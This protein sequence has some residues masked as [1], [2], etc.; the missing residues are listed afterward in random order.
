MKAFVLA[1]FIALILIDSAIGERVIRNNKMLLDETADELS[2]FKP[3]VDEK[4]LAPRIEDE[5]S[6][7]SYQV[8]KIPES[9]SG[10]F[11]EP[12]DRLNYNEKRTFIRQEDIENAIKGLLLKITTRDVSSSTPSEKM[13]SSPKNK[14]HFSRYNPAQLEAA[15]RYFENT[16]KPYVFT[17]LC[18]TQYDYDEPDRTNAKYNLILTKFVT[19]YNSTDSWSPYAVAVNKIPLEAIGTAKYSFTVNGETLVFRSIASK[20]LWSFSDKYWGYAK[21]FSTSN[22]IDKPPLL[23]VLDHPMDSYVDNGLYLVIPKQP[24]ARL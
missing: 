11:E 21:L 8:I 9:S 19:N 12:V 5:I 22:G 16:K 23:I 6:S 1:L 18:G 20:K 24:Y 13:Y 2:D 3:A 17:S 4:E 10:Y 15:L 7:I 14:Y